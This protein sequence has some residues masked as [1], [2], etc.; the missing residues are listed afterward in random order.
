MRKRAGFSLNELLIVLTIIGLLTR[1][2]LPRYADFRSQSR[3]RAV[4][5]DYLAIRLASLNYYSD[6]NA[7][8]ANTPPG[9]AP[10][11]LSPYLPA[12]VSFSRPD[13][14]LEW[15]VFNQSNWVGPQLVVT[16]TPVV[17][18]WAQDPKLARALVALAR[19]GYAH[20][21]IGGRV[22]FTISGAS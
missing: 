21:L 22:A 18:I 10:P 20:V 12:G 9:S 17:S 4:V 16:Q 5:G 3:A 19:Q 15:M 2:G 13:V 1:F 8:P 11:G 14:N 6:K 7:W